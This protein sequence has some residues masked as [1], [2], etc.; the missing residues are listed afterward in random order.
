MLKYTTLWSRTC[1]LSSFLSF[2]LV[3]SSPAYPSYSGTNLVERLALTAHLMGVNML[4]AVYLLA[5]Q[6]AT[7]LCIL[8]CKAIPKLCISLPECKTAEENQQKL[9]TKDDSERHHSANDTSNRI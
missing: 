9:G 7:T 2:Y 4:L 5:S 3:L 6:T 8:F 1:L